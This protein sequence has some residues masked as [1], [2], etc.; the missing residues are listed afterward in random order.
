[1]A[2][3]VEDATASAKWI[4]EALNSSGYRADFTLQSLIEVDRFIDEHS[5][6][7]KARASGLLSSNLGSR[8]FALGSYVGEV[9]RRAYGGEWQGNDQGPQSE[10]EIMIMFDNGGVVWPV[11]K[12]M[13]RFQSRQDSLFDY[14]VALASY[15]S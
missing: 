14:G 1:M 6:A 13:K 8:L 5:S 3:L 7:G 9:L 10:I 2:S 4:A 15:T 12:V 11:Q